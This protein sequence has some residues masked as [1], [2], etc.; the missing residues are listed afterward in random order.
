[1]IDLINFYRVKDLDATREF[2]GHLLGFKLYK[3]Q[4][5]CLIFDTGVG[6][7]GFC[8]HFP[9]EKSKNSCITFVYTSMDEVDEIYKRLTSLCTIEPELNEYFKIYHFFIN[10]P[11]GLKL[12]FQ[13]FLE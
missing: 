6:K 12:E 1:M 9:E 10:D 2:Y 5:K 3:D 7:L 8:N 11:N 13:C 4:G